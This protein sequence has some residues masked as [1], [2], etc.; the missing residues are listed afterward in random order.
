MAKFKGAVVV[1]EKNCKGCELCVKA[2]PC[3]DLAL[4]ANEVN[5]RGYHYALMRNPEA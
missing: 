2:C 3:D 5:D 1:N 4:D